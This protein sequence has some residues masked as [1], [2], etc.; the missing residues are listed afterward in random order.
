MDV[1][2]NLISDILSHNKTM[3][4]SAWVEKGCQSKYFPI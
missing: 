3:K 2:E 4:C 1:Y